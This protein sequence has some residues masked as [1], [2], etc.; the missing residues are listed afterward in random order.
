MTDYSIIDY[1]KDAIF[2]IG[3]VVG[4]EGRLVIVK[5]DQNKNL[6]HLVYKGE[7]IKNVGVGG[8]VKLLKGYTALVGKVESEIL[9]EV[10]PT[11]A[12]YVSQGE[13]MFRQLSIKLLGYFDNGR[14]H[15]GVK[16]MPLIGNV[17]QLLD[18]EE[19]RKIHTFGASNATIN[20]GH[21]LTDD[22]IP[23]EIGISKLLTSHIG[24]FGNTG[25]GKSYTLT[26]ILH[27][28]FGQANSSKAF[29]ENARFVVFDFNGEYSGTSSII[30][31]KKSYKLSTR[32]ENGD[33]IPISEKDILE[34]EL[35][36]IM[37]NAT[38]KTQQ[39]FIKRAL[40]L[41][42]SVQT[43][44]NP[45]DYLKGILRHQV[46]RIVK[47]SDGPKGK[48]ML[49]YLENILPSK[50]DNGIEVGL[51]SDLSWHGNQQC[52]Y[53]DT[54]NSRKYF[55]DE[56]Y[57]S[58]ICN[59]DVYKA[60]D[61]Y[62]VPYDTI[63]KIIH[64]LYIQ[65][66]MDV[67]NNR[68]VNEHIAPVINRLKS[69][70]KDFSKVFEVTTG[71][72][73][74]V[75]NLAVIDMN[76]VNTSMKKL[77]PLLVCTKL[78]KEH[79]N[80]KGDTLSNTLHIVIDE[81]HNILSYESNRES[82]AWKDFRLETF[83]EIIKE[84]RK[85]GVF[86]ILA[87]QRPSDISPTIISQLHN[88]LIHRLVNNRDIEMMEKS[89]SYLDKVSVESL[90]IL[91]VGACVLSGV[92]ADLP[93]IIQVEELP[94]DYQPQSENVDLDEHWGTLEFNKQFYRHDNIM[95]SER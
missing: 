27:S 55:G 1:T 39:P 46:E 16:E 67:L 81:A 44:N 57:W 11:R 26:S 15:K 89:I 91:P 34:P 30:T 42:E 59:L 62:T 37:A 76:K 66:I 83:E 8:Y 7:L 78:Y 31:E 29:K 21:L 25:S 50:L 87:S 49:D 64:Y 12:D 47:M 6:P 74:G 48:L 19:F 17:C 20:V 4:V 80:L 61:D 32:H 51:Q 28:L 92:I 79:K 14:Y 24:I 36:Y 85:F 65:L 13:D 52:F 90:P 82:E 5:V 72:L 53:T 58:D 73:W 9:K 22:N 84:G 93:V 3:E 86:L 23:I 88:Y 38:E 18:V 43:K 35:L 70:A 41:Y 10:R 75:Y 63:E 69:F 60:V 54:G 94:S 2:R 77:I 33:R 45:S 56:K 71:T 95:I 40:N 68:A